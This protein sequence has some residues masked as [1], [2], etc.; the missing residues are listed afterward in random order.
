M[1]REKSKWGRSVQLGL[2][3]ACGNNCLYL[4]NNNS[5]NIS[6]WYNFLVWIFFCLGFFPPEYH[7]C[8]MLKVK[9]LWICQGFKYS[10]KSQNFPNQ[11]KEIWMVVHS[12]WKKY[13]FLWL[14]Y[15][16][17]RGCYARS[18]PAPVWTSCWFQWFRLISMMEK[19]TNYQTW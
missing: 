4:E 11:I 10:P 14:S 5:L 3:N 19:S 18:Y 1:G 16:H 17:K 6:V 7:V 13:S 15:H 2:T 8:L 9:P 12:G